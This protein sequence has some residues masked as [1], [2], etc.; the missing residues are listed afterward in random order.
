MNRGGK[1]LNNFKKVKKAISTFSIRR[2]RNTPS[3][4]KYR[5]F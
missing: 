5:A 2:L 1:K 3:V 4:L